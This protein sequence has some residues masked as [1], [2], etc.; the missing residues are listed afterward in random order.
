MTIQTVCVGLYQNIKTGIKK[1]I[2]RQ[3]N[4]N[5]LEIKIS[6]L[7]YKHYRLRLI[8]ANQ[9]ILFTGFFKDFTKDEAIRAFKKQLEQKYQQ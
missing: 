4:N 7:G 2:K 5:M 3:R 6:Q 8:G 9:E 1:A